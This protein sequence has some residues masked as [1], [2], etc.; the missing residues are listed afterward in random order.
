MDSLSKI[1]SFISKYIVPIV[2][3]ILEIRADEKG[4]DT[5]AKTESK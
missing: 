3:L 4:D 1:L 5:I 2:D